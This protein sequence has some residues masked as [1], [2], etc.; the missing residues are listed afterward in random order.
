MAKTV[1]WGYVRVKARLGQTAWDTT[2]FP[3]KGGI[4]MIAML[5]EGLRFDDSTYPSIEVG[6]DDTTFDDRI[7]KIC[8]VSDSEFF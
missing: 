7:K 5:T 1:A 6:G 4:Y 2:L 3:A 8:R